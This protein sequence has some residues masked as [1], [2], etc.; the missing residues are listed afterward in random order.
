MTIFHIQLRPFSDKEE[1]GRR[2]M[3]KYFPNLMFLVSFSNL[4]QFLLAFVWTKSMKE[5]Q[6][7]HSMFEADDA[8]DSVMF[9]ILYKGLIL[10]TWSD[11][12]VLEKST[13]PKKAC[14]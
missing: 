4:S 10:P 11:K 9:N 7:L 12:L 6:N 1:V 14:K 2:L 5:L 8:F 13:P 3:E